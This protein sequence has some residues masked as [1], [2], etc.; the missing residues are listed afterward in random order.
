MELVCP[1]CG[2]KHRTE[3]HAGAFEILCVC[4]YSILVPDEEAM[5]LA[6]PEPSRLMPIPFEEAAE[7][8]P[9][10]AAPASAE[11]APQS[12]DMTPSEQL[13]PGMVYDPFE[14]SQTPGFPD[15]LAETN[16]L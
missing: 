1:S 4:G 3:D 15:P 7:G 9:P 14:L 5:A 11:S 2:V 6:V 16:R 8:L 12:L 10:P 13:P